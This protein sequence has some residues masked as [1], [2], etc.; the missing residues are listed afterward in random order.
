MKVL[1]VF[2]TFY[3][4]SYGG[5]EYVIRTLCEQNDTCNQFRVIVLTSEKNDYRLHYDS[6]DVFFYKTNFVY[7]Q[8]G[9]SW[10]FFR[11]FGKHVRWADV[12]HFHYPW[13]VA[14]LCNLLYPTSKKIKVL[15]YHSDIVVRKLL[16][17]FYK[18]L[19]RKFLKS[20]DVIV[21]TSANYAHHSHN[22]KKVPSEKLKI[23]PIGIN[24]HKDEDYQIIE[25]DEYLPFINKKYFLFVGVLRYYKGIDVLLKALKDTDLH[26]VIAGGGVESANYKSLA[27]KLN[28]KNV[29]FLGEIS[30]SEK[31]LLFKNA[32]AFVFPSNQRSEAFGIGLVEASSYALPLITCEI[33]TGTSFINLHEQTGYVV[34]PNDENALRDA[35]IKIWEDPEL[36]KKFGHT[37]KQRFLEYFNSEKMIKEYSQIYEELAVTKS[38]NIKN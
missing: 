4:E 37:A 6:Y 28:L 31:S 18:P 9:F 13:P 34:E 26:V 12:I 21:A 3:P 32:Y 19:E 15:T 33:G 22:L 24:H 25:N 1:H 23:I 30:E 38:A 20:M 10:S 5:I 8:I 36:A 16:H 7:A 2:K 14:D 29:W 27:K 17:F 11:D 35:M